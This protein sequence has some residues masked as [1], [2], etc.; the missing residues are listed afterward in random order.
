MIHLKGKWTADG[1]TLPGTLY[2]ERKEFQQI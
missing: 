1:M 2:L